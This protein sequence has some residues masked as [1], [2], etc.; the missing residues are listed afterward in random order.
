VS[1]KK[2]F[3]VFANIKKEGGDEL[4]TS[5]DIPHKNCFLI[6]YVYSK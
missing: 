5:Q 4:W 3:K 1:L 2:A 6:L